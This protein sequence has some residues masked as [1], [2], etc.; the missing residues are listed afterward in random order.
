MKNLNYSNDL[1]F[2]DNG[3]WDEL[4]VLTNHWVS[5]L[6]FY[7]DDLKFL[8]HLIDKYFIWLTKPEN[9]QMIKELKTGLQETNT[10]V[11]DLLEKVGKHRNRLGLLVEDPNRKDAG[12]I[13]ME[14]EHLEEEIISF[15]SFFRLNRNE[16]FKLT[17]YIMDSEELSTI[18]RG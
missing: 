17:E 13:V 11:H 16:T 8:N 15:V 7:R 14:H 12:V 2:L 10:M 4:Y 1:K 3:P 5:D 18:I 9:L 6:E